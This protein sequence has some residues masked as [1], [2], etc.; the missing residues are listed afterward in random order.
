MTNTISIGAFT[1]SDAREIKRI[2]LKNDQ[3]IN[4]PYIHVGEESFGW[5]YVV[6]KDTLPAASE[7]LEGFTQVSAAIVIYKQGLDNLEMEEVVEEELYITVTNRS[8]TFSGVEGD[9]ILVRWV[10]KEWV[11]VVGGG[12]SSSDFQHGTVTEVLGCGYYE[13]TIATWNGITPEPTSISS[14]EECDLCDQLLNRDLDSSGIDDCTVDET[15]PEF[16][17]NPT[18]PKR[19]V[20]RQ[21]TTT[22]TTVLAF[23]YASR[24]VPLA[25]WSDCLIVDKG[26]RNDVLNGSTGSSSTDNT[27]P[28]YQIVRGHQEHILQ[29]KERWECCNGVDTLIGRTPI[30][31][32]AKVC[33]EEICTNC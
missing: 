4:A 2:V 21:V 29:Y 17:L 3:T 19:I 31:F 28:V 7:P 11:P 16:E 6:L 27:E 32:V 23:D 13:V 24:F 5:H 12:G 1:S 15:L 25:L 14:S 8:L 9:V 10:I 20:T 26:D 33:S 22:E 18:D 30:I